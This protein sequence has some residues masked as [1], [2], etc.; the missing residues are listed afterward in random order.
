MTAGPL[1]AFGLVFASVSLTLSLSLNAVLL[2]A[3]PRLRRRGAWVERRAATAALLLPPLLALAV[4]TALAM[5]SMLALAAGTDHCL[6]HDHHLHLCVRHGAAWLSRPWALS[7]VAATSTFVAVR[8]GL[9]CWAHLLA[10]RAANRLRSVGT[11]LG[12]PRAYLVPSPERFAF[13]A[14]LASPAVIISQGAWDALQPGERDAIVTHE[15]AHLAHGDL[16]RRAALGFAA[17]LGVPLLSSQTL[18]FWELAAER[19][20][21]HEAVLLV[22]RPSTVASAML[23]L[24][25]GTPLPLAPAGA[26]FAAANDVPQRIESVLREEPSGRPASR[27]LAFLLTFAALSLAV[28]CAVFAAPLHHALETLLG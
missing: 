26:V 27:R 16:W 25:R 19:L 6:G 11:T 20:C 13:T 10:Q 22:D 14:G 5:E 2:L 23:A 18:R 28:A 1:I 4:V 7:L 21:D 15:L 17:S 12:D 8:F 3:K 24:A 9:A